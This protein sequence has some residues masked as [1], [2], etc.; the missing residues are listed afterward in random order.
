[1]NACHTAIDYEIGVGFEGV[2]AA[3]DGDC[4]SRS[5]GD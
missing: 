5:D 4:R 2:F 3:I 1:M